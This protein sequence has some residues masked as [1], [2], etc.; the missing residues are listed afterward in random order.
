MQT[1]DCFK[2]AKQI[3]LVT[4]LTASLYA[5]GGGGG[6]SGGGSSS[7]PELTVSSPTITE[8]DTGT[9]NLDFVV[10]LTGAASADVTVDYATSNGSATTADNDYVAISPTTLTVPA[11]STSATISVMVNN[12]TNVE[13]DET[14]NLDLS[15][16]SSNANLGTTQAV[17]TI[18]NND[19]PQVSISNAEVQEGDSGSVDM[20]FNV[21]LDVAGIG[22]ITLDY[23]TSDISATAGEDYTLGNGSLTIAE[24]DTSAEI[25]ITVSGDT[26]P[27]GDETFS[28]GLSNLSANARFADDTAL[29]TIRTDELPQ[30]SI[31]P[32]SIDEGNSGQRQLSFNVTLSD[33]TVGTTT[34]NYQTVDIGSATADDDYSHVASGSITI[35]QGDTQGS[36]AIFINGD[37]TDEPDETFEVTL[38]AVSANV[39]LNTA[40]ATAVGTILNDDSVQGTG[41]AQVSVRNIGIREGADGE[42]PTLVFNVA[43]NPVDASSDI[44]LDYR[45]ADD[46]ATTSNNDYQAVPLTTLTIPAGNN[47][48]QIA[49]TING[50]DDIEN[51]ET[52]KLEFSNISSNATL[53]TP[54]AYGLIID[55]DDPSQTLPRVGITHSSVV[56]TDQDTTDMLF[57]VTIAE[58]VNEVVTVD[59]TTQDLAPTPSAVGGTDYNITSGTLTFQPNETTATIAVPVVGETTVENDETFHVILSNPSSNVALGNSIAIGT[60]ISDEPFTYVSINNVSILEGNAS[61]QDT[62]RF[63]VSLSAPSAQQVELDYQTLDGTALVAD[64]DYVGVASTR[65][66]IPAGNTT[67][68]I[69]ITINGDDTPEID[70]QFS[71]QLSNIT[72]NAE[73]SDAIGVGTITNND[74]TGGWSLPQD[75]D[76]LGVFNNGSYPAVAMSPVTGE[77]MVTWYVYE[78]GFFDASNLSARYS[79]ATGWGTAELAAPNISGGSYNSLRFDISMDDSGNSHLIRSYA[80]S[81]Y[82][83][84]NTP[85]TD[86][87]QTTDLT[88]GLGYTSTVSGLALASNG[89]GEVLARFVRPDGGYEA[90]YDPALGWGPTRTSSTFSF[91]DQMEMDAA[92]NV[93]TIYREP[94]GGMV[95]RHFDALTQTWS[96]TALLSQGIANNASFGLRHLDVHA[97]GTAIAV[98]RA[99]DFSLGWHIYA[100]LYDGTNWSA[101]IMLDSATSYE[102]AAPKATLDA[103]GNAIVIWLNNETFPQTEYSIRS[104]RYDF[105]SNSWSPAL[106]VESDTLVDPRLRNRS[107]GPANGPTGLQNEPDV[108]SL[109][110]NDNGDAIVVWSED[111]DDDGTHTVRAM[112]Y[113]IA[114]GWSAPEPLSN[115]INGDT[116]LP[117]VI[118]DNNGNGIAVWQHQLPTDGSLDFHVWGARYTAP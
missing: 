44:T 24:G 13:M 107:L 98:W 58:P 52:F 19:F 36:I 57:S 80:F 11:G 84:I 87:G 89:S 99:F 8:G 42:Q 110:G 47:T 3:L 94:G 41:D 102:P 75:L 113:T 1:R 59:Y 54:T 40:A 86:W 65:L 51:D 91:S 18:L 115:D 118:M 22:D 45:T 17:G 23:T 64:S 112:Q 88:D 30:V 25:R 67:A 109:T 37:T 116:S 76:P 95:A 93:I 28:I 27:E 92:G 62:L 56:E 10:S 14:V 49:V 85:L 100:N 50:D 26:T 15:N 2:H 7:T 104:R 16:I 96:G 32:A 46:T 103:N 114:D 111:V 78:N 108:P 61:Q 69:D 5:C 35:A 12:D 71:V 63:T 20:V 60:I 48:A 105:G 6:G 9:S 34:V 79:P 31:S 82:T 117:R 70:E 90:N 66:Q 73:I 33:P 53:T 38:T 83:D 21:T 68:F 97:N 101:P 29:G 43:V 39:E 74:N 4:F 72:A 77:A 106:G 81:I 55:D